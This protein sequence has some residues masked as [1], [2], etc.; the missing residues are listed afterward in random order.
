[1]FIGVLQIELFI[2]EAQS[3]KDK[4]R[5]VRS[6]IERV[7]NR[8]NAAAA[9]TGRLDSWNCCGLGFVFI[10]NEAGHLD[11]MMNSVANFIESQGSCEVTGISTEIIP[12]T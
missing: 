8:F 10:S 5:V 3:L 2:G 12:Y 4:R 6:I 7:R 9:E 1:M 11:S